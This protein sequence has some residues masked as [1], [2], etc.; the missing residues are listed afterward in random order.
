MPKKLSIKI[1][2]SCDADTSYCLKFQIY[3]GASDNGAEHGLATRVVFDLMKPYLDKG[4]HLYV[5]N[6]YT[7]LKL[8][9]ELEKRKTYACGTVRINRGEFPKA[10]KVANLDVGSSTYLRMNYILAVHWKDKRDVFV[11]SS[12]HGNKEETIQ[13]HKGENSKPTMIQCYSMKMG[14]VDKCDQRLSYYS[15]T[16]VKP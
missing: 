12:I 10:F 2:A 9:Q 4:Y 1:W 7:S 3:T 15:R 16:I 14:G 8:I 11:L 5:D 13:S 6:F